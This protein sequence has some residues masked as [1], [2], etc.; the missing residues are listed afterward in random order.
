MRTLRATRE[1]LVLVT[2]EEKARPL[3]AML[4]GPVGPD[5]PASFLREH[6]CMTVLCD[7][8]AAGL[9]QPVAS[10]GSDHVAVVLGHREP[11]RSPEHRISAHSRARLRRADRLCDQTPIRAVLLT[12]YTHTGGLSEAEQMAREWRRTDVPALLEVAGRNTAENAARSLPLILALG[13]VRRVSVVSSLW[14]LRVPFFFAPYRQF[15][16]HVD[17][18]PA[19]PLRGSAHLLAEELGALPGMAAQRRSAM[20]AVRL[21]AGRFD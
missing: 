3:Q 19:P 6:A 4:E 5:A 7:R 17:L 18:R 16:L 13:G 11:G 21:P 2:G 9:L 15:G 14:H 8:A 1:I 20:G 10:R 12:G